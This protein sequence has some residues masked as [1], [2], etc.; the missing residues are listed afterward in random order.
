MKHLV[1]ALAA[2]AIVGCTG[3]SPVTGESA[4]VASQSAMVTQAGEVGTVNNVPVYALLIVALGFWMVRT[5]WG[6][7][8]DFRTAQ[9]V[10]KS[11]RSRHVSEVML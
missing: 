1:V 10:R 2:L 7:I 4:Q 11:G 9:R 6:I 3:M 8:S 5:P